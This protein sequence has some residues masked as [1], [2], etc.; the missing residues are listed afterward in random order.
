MAAEPILIVT[1][2]SK[3]YSHGLKTGLGY[4]L[5]DIA[6]ELRAKGPSGLRAGEFWALTDVSFAVDP[7]DAVAV[8]GLNGSGKSTLL[9][10]ISGLLKPDR[11]EIRGRGRT[12][13]VIELGT[14]FNPLLSGRENIRVA[15]SLHGIGRREFARFEEEVIDFAEL[16]ASIEAPV[17]SY[18]SG[19]KA[20]LSYSISAHLKPDLFLVDEA[21]TV[22]DFAFQR[23]C[24]NH[25]RAFLDGGGSLLLVSHNAFQ[26]QAVCSR[27]I[28][29]DQGRL[30]FAGS[31]VDSLNA[32]FEMRNRSSSS[33]VPRPAQH[34][35]M[36]IMSVRA[37]GPHGGTPRTGE[38]LSIAVDY[39]CDAPTRVCW[40]FAIYS[41]DQ[42]VCITGAYCETVQ[43]L[44]AGPGR[45]SC[46]V[47]RLPLLPGRYLLWVAILDPVTRYPL[48]LDRGDGSGL[49]LHVTGP[50]T[51]TTNVQAQVQQLV[52]VDVCWDAQA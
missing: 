16:D 46:V 48:T 42:I 40:S 14:A 2:L 4:G 34:G 51:A 41:G 30:A 47:E 3:K 10:L 13:A 23:K 17:Q 6:R 44:A 18:S 25:M 8:L 1:G 39:S 31:A 36:T 7:G 33:G 9:K 37:A 22:G 12:E 20:R 52:A 21:L 49:P 28:L 27:A 35:P 43:P 32:L 45:L 26:V 15:A 29:L 24:L 38:P 11:G 19:M 50:A 5:R